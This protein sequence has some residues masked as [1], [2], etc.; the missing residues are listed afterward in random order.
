MAVNQ[1]SDDITL[2]NCASRDFT[3]LVRVDTRDTNLRTGEYTLLV[4]L[5]NYYDNVV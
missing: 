1:V 3:Q 4:I 2:N 5:V